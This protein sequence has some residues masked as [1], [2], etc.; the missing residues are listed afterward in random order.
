MD[1]RRRRKEE[2]PG[3]ILAAA[4]EAFSAHGYAATRLE[5]VAALAG[6]T[7]GTIYVYFDTKEKLFQEMVTHYLD[8]IRDGADTLIINT[9]GTCSD[10]IRSLLEF[11]CRR[12]FSERAVREILRFIV[13]ESKTFP[14]LADAHYHEFVVPVLRLVDVLLESGISCGEFK[15]SIGKESARIIIA[16]TVTLALLKLIVEDSLSVDEA[17]YIG[18]HVNLILNGIRV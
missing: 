13:A 11:V 18:T 15:Q 8:G 5:D 1:R 2:R 9:D 17:A 16:P 10:K 3:E 6:V 7:K 14:S 4:L 12:C